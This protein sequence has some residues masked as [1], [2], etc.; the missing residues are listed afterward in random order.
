[1]KIWVFVKQPDSSQFKLLMFV[2]LRERRFSEGCFQDLQPSL[3][4]AIFSREIQS[5]Q[6]AALSSSEP[7]RSQACSQS[8]EPCFY[9][10]MIWLLPWFFTVLN[11][12]IKFKKWRQTEALKP[13]LL[14]DHLPWRFMILISICCWDM[15]SGLHKTNKQN[16]QTYKQKKF[17]Y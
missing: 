12:K 5:W 1:M 11:W 13:L 4:S 17:Y 7:P 14:E 8:C 3:Q 15:L 6:P 10:V 16:N 9:S 2:Y